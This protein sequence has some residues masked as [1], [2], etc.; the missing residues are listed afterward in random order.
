MAR[1]AIAVCL[2]LLLATSA[3]AG[4]W[5]QPSPPCRL[6]CAVPCPCHAQEQPAGGQGGR[7]EAFNARWEQPLGA[8]TVQLLPCRTFRCVPCQLLALHVALVHPCFIAFSAL[9]RFPSR[10]G[11]ESMMQASSFFTQGRL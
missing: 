7:G 4:V 8:A 9:A 2:L 6:L 10:F 11:G 1:Q 5:G 3:N